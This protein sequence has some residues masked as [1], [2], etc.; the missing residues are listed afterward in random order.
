MIDAVAEIGDQLH[1]FARLGDQ[2]GVDAVGDGRHQHIGGAHRLD[3]FLVGRGFVAHIE[4]R[5]EQLA[6]AGFDYLGEPTC[7]HDERLLL[8]HLR[9]RLPEQNRH[10]RIRKTTI[11][12]RRFYRRRRPAF[13]APARRQRVSTRY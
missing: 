10:F 3:E 8:R 1:L 13:R 5:I 7:H 12:I 11:P 4:A 6:H 9:V 2:P